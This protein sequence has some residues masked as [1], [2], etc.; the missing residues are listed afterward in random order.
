MGWNEILEALTKGAGSVNNTLLGGQG[1]DPTTASDVVA[2]QRGELPNKGIL[3]ILSNA[4][5]IGSKT[6]AAGETLRNTREDRTLS[7][8]YKKAQTKQAEQTGS[9]RMITANASMKRS[10]IQGM[11][12]K[13][14]A[15]TDKG[16][17]EELRKQVKIQQQD[18]DTRVKEAE[19]RQKLAVDQDAHNIATELLAQAKLDQDLIIANEKAISEKIRANA[20]M[21]TASASVVTAGAAQTNA[22]TNKEESASRIGLRDSQAKY[23]GSAAD[24]KAAGMTNKQVND[25]YKAALTLQINL[26]NGLVDEETAQQEWTNIGGDKAFGVDGWKEP[27]NWFSD[28]EPISSPT[29]GTLNLGQA[30]A[31][32][33]TPSTAPA[34]VPKATGGM[35]MTKQIKNNIKSLAGYPKEGWAERATKIAQEAGYDP[36]LP[37]Q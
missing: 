18:A 20:A 15:E 6:R 22:Q 28:R 27:D 4:S 21:K 26:K 25:L 30:P 33:A 19:T 5:L 35:A 10:E 31:A 23:Y 2:I 11:R 17:L 7:N 16:R 9:A 37:V 29:G 3:N 24:A 1:T 34:T 13:I 12:Q 14:D 8:E 36:N 32:T